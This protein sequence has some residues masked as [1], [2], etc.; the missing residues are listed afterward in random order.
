MQNMKAVALKVWDKNI[1]KVF[2]FRL[3]WQPEFLMEFKSLKY[4]ENSSPNNHFCEVSLKSLNIFFLVIV[5]RRTDRWTDGRRTIIDHNSTPDD[6]TCGL[7][8]ITYFCSE[9]RREIRVNNLSEAES[10]FGSTLLDI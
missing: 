1:L 4:L 2:F 9:F 3:P 5:H 7:V 6:N 10:E 8:T